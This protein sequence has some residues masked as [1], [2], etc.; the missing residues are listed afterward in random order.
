MRC[1]PTTTLVGG[2]G[3][4]VHRPSEWRPFSRSPIASHF[5]SQ[6]PIMNP[7]V[8]T[9][10]LCEMASTEPLYVLHGRK[11]GHQADASILVFCAVQSG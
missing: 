9:G 6:R 10:R 8:E 7:Q 2:Y 4:E 5:R 1:I 3:W 11:D